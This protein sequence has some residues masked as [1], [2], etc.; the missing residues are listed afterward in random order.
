VALGA[1]TKLASFTVS[2]NVHQLSAQLYPGVWPGRM[3]DVGMWIARDDQGRITGGLV[4]RRAL[5]VGNGF[6]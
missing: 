1:D 6:G 4:H 3:R 5:G 2:P